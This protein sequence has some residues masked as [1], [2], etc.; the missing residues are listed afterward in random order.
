MGSVRFSRFCLAAFVLLMLSPMLFAVSGTA[1]GWQTIGVLAILTSGAILALAYAFGHGLHINELEFLAK[2]EMY[3]LIITAVLMGSLVGIGAA[4]D[5]FSKDLGKSAGAVGSGSATSVQL[6]AIKKVDDASASLY[7]T[8]KKVK[9]VSDDISQESSRSTFCSF[10]GVSANIAACGA[11]RML[12]PPLSFGYQAISLSMMELGAVKTLLEIGKDYVFSIFLP[13]G[14][15]LRTFK[16]TRGAGGMLLA[17]GVAFY[18]VF[19]VATVFMHGI[20]DAFV[21][22]D[23]PA[24]Y[25]DKAQVHSE[26]ASLGGVSGVECDIW[27]TSSSI[28]SGSNAADAINTLDSMQTEFRSYLYFALIKSTFTSIISL[29]VMV[30]SIRWLASIAGA[31]VDV[32][33]LSKVS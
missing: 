14:L 20:A 22:D 13:I 29:L 10:F 16:F 17:V 23:P 21:A 12:V 9:S 32:S 5:E 24:G 7:D 30:T 31:D 3:Q 25:M 4:L 19:P 1:L 8:F 33:V 18:F 26:Y 28:Y 6:L 11:Y 2:E 15:I 27:E